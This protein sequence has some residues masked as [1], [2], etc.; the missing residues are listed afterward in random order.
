VGGSPSMTISTNHVAL[1]DLVQH[2][3]P[4]VVAKPLGDIEVLVPKV[5]ELENERICLAAIG[6]RLLAQ[7]RYKAS[8]ALHGN[9]TLSS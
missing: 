1:C 7:K 2:S 6:A 5:V 9:R 4:A 3:L 8:S